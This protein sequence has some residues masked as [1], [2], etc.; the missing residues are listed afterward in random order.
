MAAWNMGDVPDFES[1]LQKF[2]VKA[3]N[4]ETCSNMNYGQVKV[5]NNSMSAYF[6]SNY[7]STD[8]SS[9]RFICDRDAKKWRV[10]TDIEKD[11]VG[12]GAGS[13]DGQAREG[14]I[15]KKTGAVSVTNSANVTMHKTREF[16]GNVE[17]KARRTWAHGDRSGARDKTA[18]DF[19]PDIYGE[20]G[21]KIPDGKADKACAVS[22]SDFTFGFF[23]GIMHGI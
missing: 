7:E 13:F 20:S 4:L 23:G 9:V 6:A 17:A 1:H 15:N 5:I 16:G 3:L 10:A 11:T 12:F 21:T 2:W 8:H 18:L 19:A 14:K 22:D